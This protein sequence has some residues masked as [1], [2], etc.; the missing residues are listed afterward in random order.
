[1]GE[2]KDEK[3]SQGGK[4]AI[5]RKRGKKN[6]IK[7]RASLLSRNDPMAHLALVEIRLDGRLGRVVER[8]RGKRGRGGNGS[9]RKG[10]KLSD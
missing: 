6:A 5:R 2:R 3:N 10:K 9:H 1:M 8:A 4:R 7:T